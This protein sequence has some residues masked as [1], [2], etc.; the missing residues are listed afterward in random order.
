M[1]GDDGDPVA[2]QLDFLQLRV[3]PLLAR[4]LELTPKILVSQLVSDSGLQLLGGEDLERGF[5][6]EDGRPGQECRVR[7]A[8]PQDLDVD[9]GLPLAVPAGLARERAVWPAGRLRR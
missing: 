4:E 3:L 8:D 6:D 5:G 9:G 2:T 7:A 1:K